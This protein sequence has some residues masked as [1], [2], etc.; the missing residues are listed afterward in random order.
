MDV[1]VDATGP[2]SM[3]GQG[4]SIKLSAT[5]GAANPNLFGEWSHFALFL[6]NIENTV[7]VSMVT[8]DIVY[9]PTLKGTIL[10]LHFFIQW[11]L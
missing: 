1:A 9:I 10:S 3:W 5:K 11:I 6:Y 8:A 2:R 4:S 7:T